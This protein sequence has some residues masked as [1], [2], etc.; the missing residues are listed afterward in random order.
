MKRDSLPKIIFLY[1]ILVVA[2]SILMM[3]VANSL[4]YRAAFKNTSDLLY[5][6]AVNLSNRHRADF[7]SEDK[8]AQQKTIEVLNSVAYSEDIRIFLVA[9]DGTIVYDSEY[10]GSSGYANGDASADAV[11]GAD[12][13]G[14]TT[15][16]T[17]KYKI[18]NFDS[19]LMAKEHVWSGDFYGIFDENYM[20]VFAPVANDFNT[21]GYIVL[22]IPTHNISESTK[23]YLIIDMIIILIGIGI[24]ILF[25][26]YF[27]IY[28]NR[29]LT[30]IARAVETYNKGRFDVQF[31]RNNGGSI[32][33]LELALFDM[34]NK[35]KDSEE[36][37]KA[38]LSNISHDFR[39]PL[40]S[41]IGYLEAISDG[42]IPKESM[43][44]YIN[45][46]LFEANRLKELTNDILI[47]GEL[48]ANTIRL[49][50]STFDINDVIRHVI[51]TF[52][53]VC[54][55][56]NI[57]FELSF[58]S[59]STYIYADEI[60]YQQ[61]IYNLVDNAIKFS[62]DNSSIEIKIEVLDEKAKKAYI[63]VRDHGAGISEKD[64]DKIWNRFYKSDE[65]RGRNKKS[66]GLGLSIVKGIIKAHNETIDIES[67]YGE[68]TAFTFTATLSDEV[69][70][71]INKE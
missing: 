56:R 35:I 47:L 52:D 55:K 22:N 20:S 23:G 32:G 63:T 36:Y 66:S 39:S 21:N 51:E 13:I 62:P 29:P 9:T 4:N 17:A 64:I 43:D 70:E 49:E 59:V 44:K 42:T 12:S 30:Y 65:S 18:S 28:I 6:Q 67:V 50:K 8:T 71:K 33:E 58:D 68:E 69:V 25:F 46:V 41:I 38:F 7:F 45:I 3:F 19:V 48:D 37:Q 34:A 5:K 40:T 14:N 60:K 11:A 54:S 31:E 1:V 57:H 16:S 61:V 2:S 53:G 15:N 10:A 26:L 27:V 24:S